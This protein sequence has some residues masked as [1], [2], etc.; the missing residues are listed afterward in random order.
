MDS[1]KVKQ[2]AKKI[3]LEPSD[4]VINL[5]IDLYKNITKGLQNLEDYFTNEIESQNPLSRVD[6]T[7]I[8]FSDLREDIE[9][10]TFLINKQ[11]IFKNSKNVHNDLIYIKKVIN[12]N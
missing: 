12:D 2:L 11:S 10:K 9:D 1:E 7:A 4:E 6:E 3:F 8:N 5:T